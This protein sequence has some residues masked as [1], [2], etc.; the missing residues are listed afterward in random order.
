MSSAPILYSF[1]RCPYAIRARLAIQASGVEVQLR[2]II[3][4]DKAPEF[5]TSSPKGTVPVIV[6]GNQVIE[7]S[8]D[9]MHW[10]LSQSDPTGWLN[11]PNEGYKWISRNDGPFKAALDHTKYSTEYTSRDAHFERDKATNFLHDL[12]IQI[13]N[14]PWMFGR[15]CTLADVAI[16]PFV[17]QFANID[18]DWFNAQGWQNLYHWL[19]AFLRSDRFNSAMTKYDKWIS[20]DP[21]VPFPSKP[22]LFS[23]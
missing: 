23:I 21:V 19:T 13:G 14:R 2:E 6:I 9:I 12:N 20:G 4:R 5:L 11:M 10:T 1:R 15:N 17:R 8:I 18:N 7:E 3:L 16:L 22:E